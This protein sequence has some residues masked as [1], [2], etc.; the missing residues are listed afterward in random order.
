MNLDTLNNEKKKEELK[1]K[2]TKIKKDWEKVVNDIV[3]A[4]FKENCDVIGVPMKPSALTE[5]DLNGIQIL[6]NKKNILENIEELKKGYSQIECVKPKV[7]DNFDKLQ[8]ELNKTENDIASYEED[9]KWLRDHIINEKAMIETLNNNLEI[10]NNDLRNNKDAAKLR[11]LGSELNCST[12]KDIC[13]VCH[14]KISDSLLPNV[15]G[16]EIMSIDVNIR[17]LNAQKKMLEYAKESHEKNREDMDKKLQ[18][19]HGKIFSLRKLAKAI[20]SDLY[21]VDDN[22]SEALIYKKIEFQTQIDHLE[23]LMKFVDEQKKALVKLADEWKAYLQRKEEL[24]KNKF[25]DDDRKKIQLLRN[26][27]V[28]NLENYNY[29]SV[30]DKN[31]INI[32]ED[33][34]LPIVEQFDM[35]FDSSASDNVRGIWAYTVALQ[36][37]SMNMGGNHPR[38]LIFDEPVQHSIVPGDMKN[39]LDSIIELGKNCQTIIGITVKDSDTQKK[40]DELDDNVCNLIKVKNKAFQK[41]A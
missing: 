12:S 41:L 3:T 2:E 17:H 29:K 19:L 36:Q 9:V 26:K 33:N 7:V 38:V 10:I 6:K 28:A 23:S 1:T 32:S 5:I 20:R 18:L 11:E 27:F 13:P 39:F 24:P 21:S 30:I 22:L 15:E 4:C 40:I 16:I 31:E 34:Y 8:E 14:Q 25:T 35:K 37:V